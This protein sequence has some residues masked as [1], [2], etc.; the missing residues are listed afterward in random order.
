MVKGD[1]LS[2]DFIEVFEKEEC[3]TG[4]TA[5][6]YVIELAK[7]LRYPGWGLYRNQAFNRSKANEILERLGFDERI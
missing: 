1:S 4:R 6:G 3:M 2:R 7:E 5:D